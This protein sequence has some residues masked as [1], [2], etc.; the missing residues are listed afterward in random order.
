MAWLNSIS[1]PTPTGEKE[2]ARRIIW[3]FAQVE[4]VDFAGTPIFMR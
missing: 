3:G 4:L 1:L 2:V